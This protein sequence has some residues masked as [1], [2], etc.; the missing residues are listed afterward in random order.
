MSKIKAI[1]AVYG[2]EAVE[3]DLS[4]KL[5]DEDFFAWGIMDI[6]KDELLKKFTKDEI[7][8]IYYEAV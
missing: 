2:F 4:L 7:E 8:I 3:K 1:L 5:D 6:S